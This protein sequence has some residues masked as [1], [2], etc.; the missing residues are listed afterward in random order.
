MGNKL[1]FNISHPELKEGEVFLINATEEKFLEIEEWKTKRK[2]AVAYD[3]YGHVI[4]TYVPGG[5][6]PV[7][8]QRSELERK[9]AGF[10]HR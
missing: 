3:V 7:F 8:I 9:S 10:A 2:G 5:V 1:D 4:E 6:Y